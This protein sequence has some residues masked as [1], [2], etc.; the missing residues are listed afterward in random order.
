MRLA[1]AAVVAA[2]A[3]LGAAGA[4]VARRIREDAMAV[5]RPTER[6]PL[7]VRAISNETILL[8][9]GSE[10]VRGALVALGLRWT[11]GAAELGPVLEVDPRGALTR[12]LGRLDGSPP[13]PGTRA[14]I[15]VTPSGDDPRSAHG[16]D[17]EEVVYRAPGGDLPAWWIPGRSATCAVIVH[18]RGADREEGLRLLGPLAGAGLSALIIRYR[19]DPGCPDD[20]LARFG[21]T[22]W[23]DLAAAAA[24]ARGRGAERLVPVGIS[25]GGAIVMAYLERATD[26]AVAGAILDSP[27]LSLAETVRVKSEP[28]IGPLA[29]LGLVDLGR[30]LLS[31]RH[32]L[33]WDA[34]D[35]LSRADALRVPV[36]LVHDRDDALIPIGTSD[37]FAARRPDLVE[38]LVTRRA[39]HTLSWNVDPERYEAAV[40]RFVERV[41]LAP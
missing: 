39:G 19:N 29:R 40:T 13:A 28:V 18:G 38:Y 37:A 35:Y 27:V 6:F 10:P 22:E 30:R 11:G 3:L 26:D 8:D 2:G 7:T 14:G 15:V 24:Y 17:Y 34:I 31:W 5:R 32:G 21:Q 9:P 20:G 33:D 16:L 41:A 25:M 12:R 1:R 23:E 36:L 4:V